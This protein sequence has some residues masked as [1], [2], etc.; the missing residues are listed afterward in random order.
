MTT[1]QS[2]LQIGFGLQP[3][4]D[5]SVPTVNANYTLPTGS[6]IK[7]GQRVHVVNG[8]ANSGSY[9]VVSILASDSTLVRQ[10]YPGT[11]GL[12]VALQD[13]P[14]NQAH[15][16]AI[17]TVQSNWAPFTQAFSVGFGT[18]LANVGHWR[19]MGDLLEAKGVGRAGTVTSGAAQM[20]VPFS[21]VIDGTKADTADGVGNKMGTYTILESASTN[22]NTDTNN[23]HI[24]IGATTVFS[25]GNA[26]A[27]GGY[28]SVATNS[29]LGNNVWFNWEYKAPVTAWQ[30][31][32]G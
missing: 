3:I 18:P 4:I 6:N 24:Y 31:T 32:R 21:L 12:V 7:A 11:D 1:L 26:T 22:I 28:N 27:T 10:V 2:T 15:W 8:G 30:V 5:Y 13:N 16:A 29:V 14:T 17:G 20:T 25:W 23:G 9:P 19:R